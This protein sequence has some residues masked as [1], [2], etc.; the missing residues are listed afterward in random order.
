M[1]LLFLWALLV[2]QIP[3]EPFAYS[4]KGPR[5]VILFD[6]DRAPH[7]DQAL[8][9]LLS[10]LDEEATEQEILETTTC[11]VRDELFDQS[12]PIEP[13]IDEGGEI[14]L[15]TFLETRTGLCRHYALTTTLLIDQLI[16]GGKLD[17]EVYLIREE[18]PKGRHG[19]TLFL[20]EEGAW[21]LDPYWDL[22]KNGKEEK[23]F[24]GLCQK[25]GKRT[26]EKQ[27]LRW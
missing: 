10:R 27:K 14:P 23:D 4:G 18:T 22:L 19:W 8:A 9:T 11:F 2:E 24:L 3:P 6:K 13:L 5:E 26:M 12:T 16:K 15:E 17:G 20:S 21:H 7:F 1:T 25:Y